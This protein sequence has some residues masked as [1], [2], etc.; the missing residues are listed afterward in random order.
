MFSLVKILNY[1][2]YIWIQFWKAM[3]RVL[4]SWQTQVMDKQSYPIVT[5]RKAS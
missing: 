2:L 5:H 1:Q 4:A 3:L